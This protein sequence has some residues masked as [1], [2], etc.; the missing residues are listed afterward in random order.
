MPEREDFFRKELIEELRLVESKM[1]EEPTLERKIYYFS[2]AFGITGRTYKYV[3]SKDVLLA[4][5]VLQNVYNMLNEHMS[6]L[7][8]GDKNSLPNP[9]VF[10]Q[11]CDGIRDLA[12]GF[13]SGS[14]VIGPLENI[15]TAGFST[16]GAGNY[17]LEKGLIKL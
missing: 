7:K 8:S 6:R 15:A 10:E 9:V 11:L 16:T 14:N 17:L 1:R 5:I 12:N 3:F 2:A 4:D 13:E